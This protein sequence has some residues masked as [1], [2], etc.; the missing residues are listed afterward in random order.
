MNDEEQRLSR[1]MSDILMK[2]FALFSEEH[3]VCA[4]EISKNINL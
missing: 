3:F 4:K 2:R 1:N